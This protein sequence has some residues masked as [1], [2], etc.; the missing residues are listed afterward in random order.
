MGQSPVEPFAEA[1]KS[2]QVFKQTNA[3]PEDLPHAYVRLLEAVAY[4]Q[5]KQ[6]GGA[7]KTELAQHL[8]MKYVNE[9]ISPGEALRRITNHQGADF[10]KDIQSVLPKA[11]E[12]HTKAAAERKAKAEEAKRRA[13]YAKT[14]GGKLM[15]KAHAQPAVVTIPAS[16]PLAHRPVVGDGKYTGLLHK[17][18]ETAAAQHMAPGVA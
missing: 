1:Y 13:E 15:P 6:Y 12:E 11:Q 10:I 14:H 5:L 7:A 2:W 16:Q 17:Q 4:P 3:L 9:N 18:A 8:V